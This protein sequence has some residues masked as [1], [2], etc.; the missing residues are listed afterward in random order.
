MT[1]FSDFHCHLAD[2]RFSMCFEVVASKIA[3]EGVD[4]LATSGT[5]VRDFE[6]I[7]QIQTQ[8]VGTC[9]VGAGLHPYK[10]ESHEDDSLKQQFDLLDSLT[11]EID[12]VG[13]AGLDYRQQYVLGGVARQRAALAFQVELAEQ[14]SLPVILHCVRA[15]HDLLS[16][17]SSKHRF[18]IHGFNKNEALAR[19]YLDRGG[20]ISLGAATLR[21]PAWA[22]AM[23]KF[24]PVDRLFFETDAPDTELPGRPLDYVGSPAD[25]VEIYQFAASVLNIEL[26][27]LKSQIGRNFSAF[28]GSR[29]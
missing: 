20:Y 25:V 11:D 29:Q 27:D 7:K 18:A 4:T 13:E 16:V 8:F 15:H 10:V 22:K 21:K 24:V 23:L 14:Y 6:R 9:Y 26:A 28:F 5:D 2:P 17:L 3:A 1:G 12:F 19:Q